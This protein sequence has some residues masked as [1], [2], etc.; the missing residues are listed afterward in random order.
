[1]KYKTRRYF[2]YYCLKILFFF[3]SRVPLKAAYAI[4][5]LGGMAAFAFARKYRDAA[6]AN[7]DAVFSEDHASNVKIAKKMFINIAKNGAEWIKLYSTPPRGLGRFVTALEGRENLDRVWAE[8][9]GVLAI[10]YHFGNWELMP[11]YLRQLGYN[12]AVVGKKIYFHKYD[13]LLTG[14]RERFGLKTIYRDESPRKM[15]RELKRG[16]ILGIVPD[17]DVDSID[18]VFVDY[19]GRPAHT[20]VAPVKLAMAAG[21]KIV[22]TL[23][24]RKADN[25]HKLVFEKPIGPDSWEGATDDDIVRYTQEW[26]SVLEK[27]VRE[28]PEQWVW[29]HERWKTGRES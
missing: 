4:A 9:R 14:L 8:G 5:E 22:P 1:M 21:T 19:F 28:Y 18:G 12:G 29:L 15:L 3:I 24:V 13:K 16:N 23:V 10:G 27:Y 6:I 20:P 11:A 17:Q 2:F 26:T 7:L 25:T